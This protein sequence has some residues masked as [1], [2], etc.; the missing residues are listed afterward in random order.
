[1]A[2]ITLGI[3][4]SCDE[5][6]AAVYHS[7]KG[8]LSNER[9]S[10]IALHQQY[11]GVVPEIASR[12][13]LEKINYIVQRAL[14]NAGV[15]LEDIDTIAITHKPGLPGS[16]LVGLCFGKAVAY[17]AN[18]KLIGVNHLEGHIFSSFLEHNVPFPHMCLSVSGGHTGLYI[19]NGFG[20]Y[21]LIA[22]SLDDAAGEAFDKIAKLM[23]LGYPGGP[24]IEK[25]AQEEGF[26]DYFS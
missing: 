17:A 6:A 21:K 13:Q 26:K 24:I 19:V 12:A 16:L 2:H 15:L 5:T 23:N 1:M 10:S 7:T 9:Y 22:Y 11:G 14:D 4:T 25:M 20:D 18:K 8:L 3:E